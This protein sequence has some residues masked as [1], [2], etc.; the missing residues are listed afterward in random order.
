VS[1]GSSTARVDIRRWIDNTSP[2]VAVARKGTGI[3]VVG[4]S[5]GRPVVDMGTVQDRELRLIATLMYQEPDWRQAIAPIET[6]KVSLE[7]RITDRF[8]F[9]RCLEADRS[10]GAN[11]ENP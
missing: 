8:P 3:I 10:V 4:F 6:G 5:G 7:P 11:R 1:A 2:A 9:D